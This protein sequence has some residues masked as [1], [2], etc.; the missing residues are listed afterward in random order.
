ARHA[1]WSAGADAGPAGCVVGAPRADRSAPRRMRLVE[2]WARGMGVGSR[3]VEECLRFA[4]AA[5]YRRIMLWTR[6]VL[7]SARKIY[8]AAG[9][10]LVDAHKG[11]ESGKEF[12][13]QIWARDLR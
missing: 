6:D 2:P 5:G 10:E 4:T 12:M 11:E 9:F 3:L 7:T 8:Q 1:G 13:E